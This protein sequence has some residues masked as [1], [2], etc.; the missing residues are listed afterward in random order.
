MFLNFLSE[1]RLV[2]D[3]GMPLWP[4]VD[5]A[6]SLSNQTCDLYQHYHH[7]P[8][9]G[10]DDDD[11]RTL[12]SL[13]TQRGLPARPLLVSLYAAMARLPVRVCVSVTERSA[14]LDLI[15]SFAFLRRS[16]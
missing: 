6:L 2:P 7:R 9:Q 1:I 3:L 13:L 14:A 5:F 10:A 4:C 12:V 8:P 11:A 15:T 16:M